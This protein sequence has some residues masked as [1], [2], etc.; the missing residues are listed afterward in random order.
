MT[1]LAKPLDA[2]YGKGVRVLAWVQRD[3]PPKIGKRQLLRALGIRARTSYP[4]QA[5]VKGESLVVRM[6]AHYSP[7]EKQSKGALQVVPGAS[8]RG[9]GRAAGDGVR[10]APGP[11]VDLDQSERARRESV[12]R[13]S[14]AGAGAGEA[15][16]DR[17]RGHLCRAAP[18]QG[19]ARND[20]TC[21]W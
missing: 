2:R 1:S 3:E 16:R 14:R 15:V 6:E 19:C 20:G 7:Y 17:A 18:R 4:V 13:D 8:R 21:T 12:R 5:R 11:V 9:A 10:A